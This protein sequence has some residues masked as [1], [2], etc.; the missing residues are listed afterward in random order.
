[1]NKL[2][3]HLY[4]IRHAWAEEGSLDQ[5]D[6]DRRLTKKGR[7]RFE[8]FMRSMKKSGFSVDLIVTSPLVRTRETAEI[9]IDVL[10]TPRLE[11]HDALAPGSNWQ[12]ITE[13]TSAEQVP[14]VAWVGHAPCV[15]RLVAKAVGNGKANIRMQ[16]GTIASICL[17][18]GF[19]HS[20]E[21]QWLIPAQVIE[22]AL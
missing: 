20:G 16:K 14:R 17:E 9:M 6:Y 11:I 4:I 1:M 21:L 19:S 12:E 22:A 8:N 2:P 3:T 7:T 5:D 10:K 18:N 15:G 13:W